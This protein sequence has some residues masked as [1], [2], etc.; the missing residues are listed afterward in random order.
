[1]K[2]KTAAEIVKEYGINLEDLEK[3]LSL[4]P[5]FFDNWV[6]GKVANKDGRIKMLR[7][8]CKGYKSDSFNKNVLDE[9]Y[10]VGEILESAG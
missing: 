6:C 7:L 3:H 2:S 5:R 4:K 1:M 8:I 9:I 10:K